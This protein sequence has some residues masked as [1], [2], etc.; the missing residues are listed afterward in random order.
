[1]ATI[2]V[3]ASSSIAPSLRDPRIDPRTDEVD[4]RT[5]RDG[6]STLLVDY[7]S[8]SACPVISFGCAK[9][10]SF[11]I[12]GATSAMRPPSRSFAFS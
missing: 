8:M 1:M 9:P 4:R 7:S 3:A 12:V 2:P 5:K 10:R 6:S 11:N